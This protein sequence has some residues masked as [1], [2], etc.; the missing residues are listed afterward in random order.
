[1]MMLLRLFIL[2]DNDRHLMWG[3]FKAKGFFVIFAPLRV[4]VLM[5]C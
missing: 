4:P 5:Y 2:D 1:M 3:K